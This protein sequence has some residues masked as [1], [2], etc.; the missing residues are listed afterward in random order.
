MTAAEFKYMDD[1]YLIPQNMLTKKSYALAQEA[2]RKAARW[3]REE[4]SGLFEHKV[5]DPFIT[6]F[7]PLEKLTE[8]TK[9]TEELLISMI[10][11]IRVSDAIKVY[12]L[13][14][15]SG[16]GQL[17]IRFYIFVHIN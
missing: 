14:E 9:P 10:K 17:S 4:H 12:Q 16:T 5:A 13:L 8:N 6:A 1:P 7:A 3:I 2:G 15:N 11:T